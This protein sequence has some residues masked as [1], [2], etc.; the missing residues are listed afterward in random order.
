MSQAGT[1]DIEN[2]NPQ[3]P[4]KFNADTGSAV[5][6]ENQ[7]DILGETVEN[8]NAQ[9]QPVYTTASGMTVTVN[10][11]V[12]T[13]RTG[14]PADKNDA[15][16]VSFDDTMFTVD[17]NGYV[18]LIGG[19][20]AVDSI[21]VDAHTDPGTD[22]VLADADGLI[23][24]TGA[25]VATGEV[26]AN[27][28]RTNSLEAN[29]YTIEIQRSTSNASPDANLNGVAHFNNDYLSVDSSGF[30][31]FDDSSF[32]Q[33]ITGD[34]GGALSP[35]AG[36]WNIL[37]ASAAAGTSPVATSGA[38]STLTVNVQKS[39]AI[40]A[41]NATNVGL[42]AF[43][44]AK[45]S[46][47]ANGFV[48]T[49]STGIVTKLTPDFDFDGTA[50]TAV[51]PQSGNINV[52]T[53]NPSPTN[54]FTN[55]VVAS[56]NSTGASTGD[57]KIENRA[58]TTQYIVDSS[59]TVGSRGT[60]S[61]LASAMAAAS[62][63]DT[64]FIRTS[65]T[66]DVTLTAGVNIVGWPVSGST[67]A[68]T[69]TGKLTL[70]SAGICTISGIHL[71]T[72]GDYF[73]VTSGAVAASVTLDKCFLDCTNFS[74]IN[75]SATSGSVRLQN[76][77]SDLGT[78]GIALFTSSAGT[79]Q[80]SNCPVM[81]NS[82]GSTTA[83]T[84]SA[85]TLFCQTTGW[86]HPLSTSGT[87]A[88]QIQQAYFLTSNTTSITHN[89]S[90]TTSFIFDSIIDS[91]SASAISIGASADVL[92]HNDRIVSSNTNAITGS[93]SI[94]YGGLVFNGSSS[95]INTTSQTPSTHSN[96]AVKV[97][98][99]GAY[100]YTAV[101]QDHLILVDTS[102]GAR[103]IN[104]NASPQTGQIYRIKDDDGNAATNNITVTPAAGNIDGAGSY[105][106]NVNYASIT[107]IYSGSQWVVT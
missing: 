29:Q 91:G 72:N 34:S 101:P 100:P 46:V 11:Q 59:T 102:G 18:Q 79:F 41:T 44:S 70:S 6:I 93:G 33:T 5:P 84:K 58:W 14:A 7:L 35:T 64:I 95:T 80:M 66:E 86:T 2:A 71:V 3:I 12:G 37:G 19:T 69:I 96:D 85:G 9:G 83:S 107:V 48:S 32:G 25:Q 36:N 15:G 77:S 43:D 40:G 52:L 21:G 39:Q 50:A 54:T 1:I 63:G 87:C 65:V 8:P 27:V 17:E 90:G 61:T 51:S 49:A 28:I 98:T 106:I 97:T 105:S 92:V 24:V 26:G 55:S 99:P 30:V 82:G 88:I 62:A 78:T 103:T 67:S 31:S 42:A 53:Y 13:E 68:P 4:T 56:L 23:T 73:L 16:L 57:I 20:G 104:L 22:P 94:K 60:Y 75:Q 47:D 45:F 81:G 76:C 38:G 10:V 74:G 89:G